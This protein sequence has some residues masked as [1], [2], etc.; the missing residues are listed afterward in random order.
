M[1]KQIIGRD[2]NPVATRF[3]GFNT[4]R[5]RE[6]NTAR[7]FARKAQMVMERDP[8]QAL[9]LFDEAIGRFHRFSSPEKHPL[10]EL[11]EAVEQRTYVLESSQEEFG[12]FESAR[13]SAYMSTVGKSEKYNKLMNGFLTDYQDEIIAADLF[14]LALF[15]G[16]EEAAHILAMQKIDFKGYESPICDLKIG[17]KENPARVS[18]DKDNIRRG[19]SMN[20]YYLASMF[21]STGLW[22]EFGPMAEIKTNRMLLY[23]ALRSID[24]LEESAEMLDLFRRCFISGRRGNPRFKPGLKNLDVLDYDR[25]MTKAVFEQL[26]F[27]LRQILHSI[28]DQNEQEVTLN[29]RVLAEAQTRFILPVIEDIERF[30]V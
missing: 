6:L 30:R 29:F 26:I 22:K 21:Y 9:I 16:Y 8:D 2:F 19:E 24:R 11:S 13:K 27:N 14:H 7:G 15:E 1:V 17:R 12:K 25:S 23:F 28:D 3:A 20:P 10:P 5:N 18:I 4:Y